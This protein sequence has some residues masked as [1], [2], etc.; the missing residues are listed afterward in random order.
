MAISS[1]L[2]LSPWAA[3]TMLLLSVLG[4]T[5]SASIENTQPLKGKGFIGRAVQ[6]N[7][8]RPKTTYE[9]ASQSYHRDS[10]NTRSEDYPGPLGKNIK[11]ETF[12]RAP[13]IPLYWDDQGRITAGAVCRESTACIV[14]LNPKTYEVEASY[15]APDEPSADLDMVSMVYMQILDGHVTVPARGRHVIDVERITDAAGKTSFVKRRDIDLSKVTDEGSRIIGSAY[16]AEGNLWF[17]TGGYVGVNLPTT[18]ST[19]VGFV[20]PDGKVHSINSPNT[21]AENNFAISGTDVYL[22]LGPAGEADTTDA[23]AYFYGFKPTKDGVK[24][25]MAVPYQAGDGVKPGGVSRGS[26]STP[27]LLGNKYVA[28]TDNANEQVSLH[29]VP[30]MPVGKNGTKPVCSMPM[31]KSGSSANENTI[32]NHW[33]GGSKYS[34]VVGNYYN[35]MPLYVVDNTTIFGDGNNLDPETINGPFNNIAQMTPGLSRIEYDEKTDKCTTLWTNNN[36]RGTVTPVLSTKTG[37]LYMQIQDWDLAREGQYVY[38]IT[39]IDYRTGKEVWKVRTGA[40]GSFN[41]NLQ[42]PMLTSDGG[43]GSHTV[44]GFIQV[45]DGRSS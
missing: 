24:I 33:D 9:P 4:S 44:G 21:R 28:Y 38:Y 32:L 17:T 39:A 43:V 25:A 22:I 29:I 11:V 2:R 36:I 5:Q 1:S 40:G 13:P 15:P 35:G 30:Q 37:L 18:G 10:G 26:G 7:P 45:K 16:D 19:D 8:L 20:D 6:A 14:A 23:T 12:S 34:V 27:S 42:S 41:Y 3:K 31:F